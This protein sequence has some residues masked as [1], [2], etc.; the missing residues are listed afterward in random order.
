MNEVSEVP[1]VKT[2]VEA[3]T[4]SNVPEPYHSAYEETFN[5]YEEIMA[6]RFVG[7]IYC[8]MIYAPKSVVE[9]TDEGTTAICPICGVDAVI[10][11]SLERVNSEF[12]KDMRKHWFDELLVRHAELKTRKP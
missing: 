9:W 12:L 3:N 10:P 2:E 5:H 11:M 7:C 4:S 8:L 1:S 6:S